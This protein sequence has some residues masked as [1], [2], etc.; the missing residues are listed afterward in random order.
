MLRGVADLVGGAGA[1]QDA[2]DGRMAE[3]EVQGGGAQ[4]HAVPF[5]DRLAGAG[6]GRARVR[7]RARSRR[8]RPGA[9]RR[10]GR[11]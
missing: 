6:P 11:S 2:R 8:W 7:A 9:G 3:R 5:G 10:A 1:D 4:R